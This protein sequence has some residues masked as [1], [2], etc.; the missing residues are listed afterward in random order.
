MNESFGSVTVGDVEGT[1]EL[2]ARMNGPAA[3][4][5]FAL[6]VSCVWLF[7]IC[8]A[9]VLQD[10]N[11]ILS[12]LVLDRHDVRFIRIHSWA[13]PTFELHSHPKV[14]PSFP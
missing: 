2:N 13:L 10:L 1:I 8:L 5:E 11:T 3:V 12:S 9:S 14:L 7:Y 4:Y 6:R